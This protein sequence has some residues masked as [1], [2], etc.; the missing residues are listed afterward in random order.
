[1]AR[2]S[3]QSFVQKNRHFLYAGIFLF[4]ALLP[5][6]NLLIFLANTGADSTSNDYLRFLR[7]ADQ[8]LRP[9]YNWTHYF[10][11]SFDNN[12]HCYAFLFLF[13]LALAQVTH[14]SIYAEVWLGVGL[15]LVKLG[16]IFI[17]FTHFYPGKSGWQF[18]LVPVLSALVFSP[19]QISA[20]SF[21]E[22]ALQFGMTQDFILLG[23]F[24]LLLLPR[25]PFTP[26]VMA[27][28]GVL[29][30]YSGGSGLM[31]WPV[32]L[33]AILLTEGRSFRKVIF[34]GIGAGVGIWPYLAFSTVIQN[35]GSSFVFPRVLRMLFTDLGLPLANEINFGLIEHPAAFWNGVLGCGVA[36]LMILLLLWKGSAWQRKAAV[37]GILLM[38][39][40]GAAAAQVALSRALIAPWY[41]A[42]SMLFWLG[43]VGLLACFLWIDPASLPEKPLS[44]RIY[45]GLAII[46]L[47]G[48]IGLYAWSNR[49]FEDKSFYLNSRSPSSA[50]CLANYA[51]APTDCEERVF[52]W[53]IGHPT[54]LS[55]MGSIL[56]RWQWSVFALPREKT[57]QGDFAL[58]KVALSDLQGDFR[59]NWRLPNSD[60]EADWYDYHHL[61]VI[62]A[63][64]ERLAWRVQ[65]PAGLT[66]AQ[67]QV[68]IAGQTPSNCEGNDLLISV[69][70]TDQ[71]SVPVSLFHKR[72]LCAF[73][74]PKTIHS[75]L[76]KD[77]GN[78]VVLWFVNGGQGDIRLQYPN[79]KL[80]AP[81]QP[82]F[83]NWIAPETRPANTDLAEQPAKVDARIL[84]DAA[85]PLWKIQNFTASPGQPRLTVT[86]APAQVTYM[87]PQP[88][89][90]RQWSQMNARLALSS[91]YPV[92]R[93]QAQVGY[94]RENAQT[95]EAI[96]DLPVLAGEDLHDY[97]MDLDRINLPADACL[98]W[99]RI[100]PPQGVI[101]DGS[102]WMS[103]EA[104]GF[105]VRSTPAA[106]FGVSNPP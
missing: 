65:L 4:L 21:G 56:E 89:C 15:G 11:D 47:L 94:V 79:L 51:T 10:H 18:W 96:K 99:V 1:M 95:G 71:T 98:T 100:A 29:A 72:G 14:M 6:V 7:L 61:D 28:C 68:G 66:E 41:T 60:I 101:G 38:L 75:D 2:A 58:G 77:A 78:T 55:E 9:G 32:F 35:A 104:F 20:Y 57:L 52:Q 90:L 19:S 83:A 24:G 82:V 64:G 43:L 42:S 84:F 88:L 12:V 81:R 49:T 23:L 80:N 63:S 40:S 53:G 73:T 70:L 22:T 8:V 45:W 76:L 103:L 86:G 27:I 48:V 17:Y 3:I 50:A 69:S 105:G 25:R 54:Y 13:R 85:S 16:L 93:V 62:L 59:V 36:G 26:I 31:A 37:P 46:G 106:R 44:S 33:A 74:A 67:L 102:T 5:L 39:W 91:A 34:W 30:S 97:Q 87:L 92:R